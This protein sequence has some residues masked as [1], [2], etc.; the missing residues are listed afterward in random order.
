MQSSL[1]CCSPT[2]AFFWL[3]TG[4]S[5]HAMPG[6][7]SRLQ[8]SQPTLSYVVPF[9]PDHGLNM[10]STCHRHHLLLLI[11]LSLCSSSCTVSCHVVVRLMAEVGFLI[12]T[13]DVVGPN[14]CLL[15]AYPCP[16]MQ[17]QEP[18]S[19]SPKLVLLQTQGQSFTTVAAGLR[20]NTCAQC[21]VVLLLQR[22]KP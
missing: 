14:S 6:N 22:Q 17:V 15:P 20:S 9:A 18:G 21:R 2:P 16:S 5:W 10:G 19:S 3:T 7:A 4:D 12:A 13:T 11:E 8:G 1:C